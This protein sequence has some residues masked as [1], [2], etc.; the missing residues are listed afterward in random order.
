MF[1]QE[2]TPVRQVRK[3][4]R[5]SFVAICGILMVTINAGDEIFRISLNRDRKY[6]N[7]KYYTAVLRV[8][9]YF[10]TFF[11]T[12]AYKYFFYFYIN[13]YKNLYILAS[14]ELCCCFY[15]EK[16]EL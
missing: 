3:V 15:S 6:P 1:L 5:L 16:N 7:A 14:F 2:D 8:V 9:D 4:V 11:P 12:F 10:F 13:K